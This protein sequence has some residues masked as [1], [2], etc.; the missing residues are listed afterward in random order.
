MNAAERET[1]VTTSDAEDTVRIWTAQRRFV[2]RLRSDPR[3]TIVAEGE[4]GDT[5]WI[6]AT[7]PASD[8]NPV[9]GIKRRRAPLS[10][11][12]R[13]ELRERLVQARAARS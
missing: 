7:I 4:H 5:K 13:E 8:W 2:N 9:T 11:E 6:E 1:T 12:R 3:V 10:E